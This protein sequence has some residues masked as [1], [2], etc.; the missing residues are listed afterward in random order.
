MKKRIENSKGGFTLV[1]LVIVVALL[2][3]IAA[4]IIPTVTNIVNTANV[5]TDNS[6]AQQIE[7]SLKNAHAQVVGKTYESGSALASLAGTGTSGSKITADTQVQEV[8]KAVGANPQNDGTNY[9]LKTA[10][11]GYF[12]SKTTQKVCAGKKK[13]DADVKAALGADD[14][15]PLQPTTKVGDMGYTSWN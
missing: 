5:N 11:Y 4:I 1:E 7:M 6:N 15:A 12:Y 14:G 3:I 2:A 8:L 13:D 9:T 10:N